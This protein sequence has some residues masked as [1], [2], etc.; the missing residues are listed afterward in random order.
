MNQNQG[1]LLAF[2]KKNA[3]Y[4]SGTYSS[5]R[6]T[7][8]QSSRASQKDNH[9]HNNNRNLQNNFEKQQRPNNHFNDNKTVMTFGDRGRP[10]NYQ[11]NTFQKSKNYAKNQDDL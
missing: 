9:L 7:D 4:S 2:L 11:V 3:A 10:N 8:L 1:T 5:Q 6:D